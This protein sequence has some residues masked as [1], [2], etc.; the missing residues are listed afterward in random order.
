MRIWLILIAVF[1]GLGILVAMKKDALRRLEHAD[2]ERA[3]H[4]THTRREQAEFERL[5]DSAHQHY[6]DSMKAYDHLV[7]WIAG[8][9]LAASVAVV[10][11]AALKPSTTLLAILLALSW[12]ALFLALVSTMWGAYFSTRIHSNEKELLKLQQVASL[13]ESG[14]LDIARRERNRRWAG[15]STVFCNVFSGIAVTV[16]VAALGLYFFFELI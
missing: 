15:K 5:R 6:V 9:A 14:R 12:T 2:G 1:G 11:R 13:T 8:G 7:P 10:E 4:V 16:G 3:R